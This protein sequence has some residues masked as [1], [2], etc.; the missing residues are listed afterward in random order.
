MDKWEAIHSFWA[1]FSVSAYEENSVPDLDDVIFPYITYEAVDSGFGDDVTGS[2][3]I[4]TRSMSW[5]SA[6]T[7]SNTIHDRLKN[8]GVCIPYDGGIIWMTAGSPFAQSLGD[9]EDDKIKR[10]VLNVDY[11]FA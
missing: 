7:L 9:P 6:D 5:L 1:S 10:K 3:S 4:W 2:A 8:G 11:H